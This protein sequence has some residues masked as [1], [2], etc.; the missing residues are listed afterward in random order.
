LRTNIEGTLNVVRACLEFRVP[1]LLYASSMTVY[2]DCALLPTP[3][4][5]PAIPSSYYGITKYAAERYALCTP[6][7]PDVD[8]DLAVTALRMFTVYGP[9]QALDNPYQ[10]VLGIFLG[11]LLRNE[12]LV[13][14]GDGQQ[15]RDFVYIDDVVE[16]WMRALACPATRGRVYNLGSGRPLTVNELVD[17]VLAAFGRSRRNYPVEYRHGR[18]GEQR[19]V[20]ANI[21]RARI[22][23]GWEPR[24]A[25]EEGL[26]QT[27]RW[28]CHMA[29]DWPTLIAPGGGES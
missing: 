3:E 19:H 28:A 27:V 14:Y 17:R 29:I 12:P 25:F 4:E 11:N 24:I 21:E 16:G 15:S 23:L 6:D 9:G 1:R 7:R 10:G 13:I 5:A 22:E 26:T 2:G 20:A 8:F 18:P